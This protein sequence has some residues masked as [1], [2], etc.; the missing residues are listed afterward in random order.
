MI[1]CLAVN[2]EVVGLNPTS[3]ANVYKC[4]TNYDR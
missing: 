2:E 4:L 3:P 1:E